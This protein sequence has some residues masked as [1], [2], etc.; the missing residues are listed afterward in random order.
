MGGNVC[1]FIYTDFYRK[2]FWKCPENVLKMFWKAVHSNV[3]KSP[4]PYMYID[5]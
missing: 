2:M 1:V 4:T 3:F 5:S